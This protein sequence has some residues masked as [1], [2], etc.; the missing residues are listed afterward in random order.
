ML[1]KLVL[2]QV[3]YSKTLPDAEGDVH[4]GLQVV[5]MACGIPSIIQGLK[6]NLKIINSNPN[7]A[8]PFKASRRIWTSNLSASHLACVPESPPSTS[9]P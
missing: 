3:T 9:Q 6:V 1:V 5:E 2:I 7:Q 4:R 8:K